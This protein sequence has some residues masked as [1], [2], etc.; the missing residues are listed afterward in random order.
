MK[1]ITGSPSPNQ[2]F[3][4]Y[5]IKLRNALNLTNYGDEFVSLSFAER[6]SSTKPIELGQFSPCNLPKK[7]LRI[8]CDW[9]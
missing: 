1:S 8:Y 2:L 7:I 9:D 5:S 6:H 3:V 4:K